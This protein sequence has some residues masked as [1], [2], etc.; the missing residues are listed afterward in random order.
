MAAVAPNFPTCKKMNTLSTLCSAFSPRQL[1]W[2]A[3]L[4]VP[5]S[6]VSAATTW[7]SGDPYLPATAWPQY[8]E[9]LS[10]TAQELALTFDNFTW[11][12]AA[13]GVVDVIGGHFHSFG[14]VS[15]TVLDTA[16]WEIR[17]GMSNNNGGSLLY[18]GSGLVTNFAT[19]FTQGGAAVWGVSVDV[20]NFSLPAGNYWLGLAVG[21]T[22]TNPSDASWFVAS[23]TGTNGLG[24]PLGDDLSIYFQSV[25]NGATINWNYDESAILNPTSTGFDPSYFIQ[26]IPEPSSL[27]L[28]LL[29]LATLFRRNR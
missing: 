7:Y 29:G 19:A 4:T 12:P 20:P 15:G 6:V 13:G 16:Y 17:T 23:T 3:C 1:G 14:T 10:T 18:S 27:L 9:N 26:E 21:T 5:A 11:S 28:S 22:S 8:T 2:I 24:S 25:S